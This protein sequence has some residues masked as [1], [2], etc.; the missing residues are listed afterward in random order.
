MSAH[1]IRLIRI[2]IHLLLRRQE[3]RQGL[4][5]HWTVEHRTAE[6]NIADA[7]VAKQLWR[8]AIAQMRAVN[9]ATAWPVRRRREMR[10][11][12][13]SRLDRYFA[14]VEQMIRGSAQRDTSGDSN[15]SA[16]ITS[17]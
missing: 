14:Q 5:L 8:G 12:A 3:R 7:H 13:E 16:R 6:R 11:E 9:T 10:T 4:G 17:R 1:P 15:G 2:A